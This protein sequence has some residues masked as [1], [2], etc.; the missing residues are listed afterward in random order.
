MVVVVV[1]VGVVV[2]VAVAAAVV[3]VVILRVK[4]N[5]L[6]YEEAQFKV[7]NNMKE[8]MCDSTTCI[9]YF[10]VR[11]TIKF[12]KYYLRLSFLVTIVIC[13]EKDS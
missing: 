5:N 4:I 6:W 10:D 11:V 3:T 13:R 9:A 2:R 12:G 8:H 1:V 7:T